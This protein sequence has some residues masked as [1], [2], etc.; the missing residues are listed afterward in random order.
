MLNQEFI[1][2]SSNLTHYNNYVIL[3]MRKQSNNEEK[4]KDRAA[5]LSFSLSVGNKDNIKRTLMLNKFW[6]NNAFL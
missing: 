6:L 1:I 4:E 3:I 2:T 5:T